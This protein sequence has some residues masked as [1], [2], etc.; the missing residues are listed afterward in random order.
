MRHGGG[1][2]RFGESLCFLALVHAGRG[3]FSFAYSSSVAQKPRSSIHA[4][5]PKRLRT[6]CTDRCDLAS[7]SATT[8]CRLGLIA[9]RPVSH[10]TTRKL[11]LRA[12]NATH[13]NYYANEPSGPENAR[14]RAPITVPINSI[15]DPRQSQKNEPHDGDIGYFW[16]MPSSFLLAPQIGMRRL[17][18]RHD[19]IV[20]TRNHSPAHRTAIAPRPPYRKWLTAG[21]IWHR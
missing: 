8:T 19:R 10:G 14:W 12:P 9:A 20:E 4:R 13:D 2:K 17:C 18:E 1:Q 7:S 21:G 15:A 16:R 5:W 6:C 3:R 11:S